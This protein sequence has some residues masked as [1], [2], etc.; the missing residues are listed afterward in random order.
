VSPGN[1]PASPPSG[2]APPAV[3]VAGLRHDYRLAALDEADLDL[4]PIAQFGR[5]LADAVAAAVPEPSAM[6]VAT[7]DASGAPS[8]RTVLLKGVDH[9]GF[10]FYTNRTSRKGSEL[11]ANPRGSLV[12]PW[13][14]LQRQV[15]VSGP[16]EVVDGAEADAYFAS[17]PRGSQIAAWASRQSVVVAGRPVIERWEADAT[18][19][20]GDGPVP[21]PPFWGGYRVVPMAVELWQG[22]P[23]R[24]HDRL[25]YR[26]SLVEDPWVVER[27]SP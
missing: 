14:E 16:V 27:L 21:R 8:A 18:V 3:D 15:L 5:W 20:F 25:R 7:A 11:G 23:S 4:D 6:V 1:P 2:S 17:R 24:L 22:R 13:L 26:R 10:V 9:R 12:F 19:R